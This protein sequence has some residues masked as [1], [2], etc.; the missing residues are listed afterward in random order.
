MILVGIVFLTAGLLITLVLAG[1]SG[2]GRYLPVLLGIIIALGSIFYEEHTPLI[3]T[4]NIV[5]QTTDYAAYDLPI[6]SDRLGLVRAVYWEA[7]WP[8]I[9]KNEIIKYSFIDFVD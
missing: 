5:V 8:L 3:E 6:E 9:I 4:K 1:E 2:P 7:T